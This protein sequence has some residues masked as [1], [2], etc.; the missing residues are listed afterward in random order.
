MREVWEMTKPVIWWVRK[1]LRLG[2]NA[3]LAGALASGA[4]VIPVF[5]LDEVFEGY[6]AAALWRFGLGVERLASSLE[7]AGSRLIFRRG[8]ALDVLAGLIEE[9]GAKAV[10][11]SRAYDPEQV[12]RDTAVKTMLKDKGLTAESHPGHL[13]F[14]PW[15]VKTKEGGYYRVYTPFWRA[16]AGR[17]VAG[18]IAAPAMIP[19]PEHWPK[20]ET[21]ADWQLGAGMRR[22]AAVV[23][24]HLAV[25]EAAAHQRLDHF[26]AERVDAYKVRRDIPAAEATS[27]LSEN[28]AWGEISPA[29]CWHAARRALEEGR[30]GAE[31]FLKEL[32]W[33][34]FAY[35]LV[36]H[37]PHILDRNWR[38]GWDSFPWNTDEGAAVR[39]W[40]QGRTGVR[41]V[42]AAMRELY[43]TGTMHNR[44]RMIVA[45]FLTK[46][47][48]TH[49]R[50]GQAW[51]AD[52]LIDWDP[53]SNAMGW[54]W[55]AG[56][57]PDAAPYFRIFN[58]DGQ[59]E[60]FDPDGTYQRRWIAEGET[61]PTSTALSY[62]EA[63]PKSWGLSPEDEYPQ[64]IVSLAEGRARALA[65]YEARDF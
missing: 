4:P 18:A 23:A 21:I 5:I 51:F 11:W 62:F 9:T 48:M 17:E 25:G 16:V 27:R 15:S 56:S 57:G 47:L 59:L 58:P 19:A 36:W 41:F 44:A 31:H 35:H 7:A 54:Q 10:H 6:G 12:A 38:E 55:V 20:S 37:T 29:A 40:Q 45:S 46:H 49:W 43:V 61:N 2:D 60:K 64:P 34:E 13:L 3:A 53:A 42:D 26:I 22:G 30:A 32:V 8:A 50:I 63:V 39:A 28:L 1:D 14:E 65:A 33:R 52:C 24:E